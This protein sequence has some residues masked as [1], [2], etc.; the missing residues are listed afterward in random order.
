MWVSV[1]V[2]VQFRLYN[3]PVC[4]E[5]VF[6]YC[7]VTGPHQEVVRCTAARAPAGPDL[8][9]RIAKAAE[10]PYLINSAAV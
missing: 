10:Y 2:V 9:G 3:R 7:N 5:R 4:F 6:V 1:F 8:A